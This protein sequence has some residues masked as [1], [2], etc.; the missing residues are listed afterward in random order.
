MITFWNFVYPHEV[1]ISQNRPQHRIQTQCLSF[2]FVFS[3][4]NKKLLI[5]RECLKFVMFVFLVPDAFVICNMDPAC[6]D[7]SLS[8]IKLESAFLGF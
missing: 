2:H 8:A 5:Q 4:S 6:L 1:G 3:V 7:C